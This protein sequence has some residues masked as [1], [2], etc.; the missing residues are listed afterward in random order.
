MVPI[1]YDLCNSA[2]QH[3][4][5]LLVFLAFPVKNFVF[6]VRLK[7]FGVFL[8]KCLNLWYLSITK[9]IYFLYFLVRNYKN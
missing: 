1:F 6:F 2:R 3:V 9:H 7:Y 4:Q 8:F 5:C